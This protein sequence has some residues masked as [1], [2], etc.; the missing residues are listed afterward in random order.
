MMNICNLKEKK[1]AYELHL[2]PP[3]QHSSRKSLSLLSLLSG[4]QDMLKDP[5]D[6]SLPRGR[7]LVKARVSAVF[8]RRLSVYKERR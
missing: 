6:A 8:R 1:K 2:L 7:A 3:C 5:P 4:I